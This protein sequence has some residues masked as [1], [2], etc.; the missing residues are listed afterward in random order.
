MTTQLNDTHQKHGKN[1]APF[2]KHF[3]DLALDCYDE[4]D[5]EA[6]LEICINNIIT[7]YSAYLENIGSAL[8]SRLLEAMRETSMSVKLSTWRSWKTNKSEAHHAL[9]VDNRYHHSPQKMK[10]RD[11]NRK[12]Y[13]P[14]A[15]SDEEF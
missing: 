3:R 8:F 7:D 14:L 13:S 11:G 10:E 4:E 2:V 15:C 5:E 6:L 12:T 1:L 9:T